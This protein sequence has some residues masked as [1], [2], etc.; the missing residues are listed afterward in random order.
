MASPAG[1]RAPLL[2]KRHGGGAAGGAPAAPP[3]SARASLLSRLE[4]PDARSGTA[5]GSV[6]NLVNSAVGSGMLCFP[7]AYRAAGLGVALGVSATAWVTTTFTLL[8]LVR[9]GN[10]HDARTLQ[11]LV[12][13]ALGRR[14]A[15]VT[16]VVVTLYIFGAC[17]SYLIILS[18]SLEV[19]LALAL[20]HETDVTL[21]RIGLSVVGWGLVYPLCLLRSL[22]SLERVSAGTIAAALFILGVVAARAFGGAHPPAESSN[23]SWV[24]LTDWLDAQTSP[25]NALPI[26]LLAYQSHIQV[27]PILYELGH[28]GANDSDNGAGASTGGD[29]LPLSS[30][31]ADITGVAGHGGLA[32]ELTTLRGLHVARVARW[33]AREARMARFVAVAS[34]MCSALYVAMGVLGYLTFGDAAGAVKSNILDSYSSAD[35]LAKVARAVVG[36]NMIVSYP[37]N[38]FCARSALCDLVLATRGRAGEEPSLALR[39]SIT[40]AFFGLTYAVALVVTN[41]GAVFDIVG[42]TAGVYVILI[43][44]AMLLLSQSCEMQ[45]VFTCRAPVAAALCVGGAMVMLSTVGMQALNIL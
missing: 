23:I 44:P 32:A 7:W 42:A 45:G 29:V 12:S 2:G 36:L 39:C 20:P 30:P 21:R 22:S 8:V 37:V 10:V 26:A 27:V 25:L 38:C 15:L 31:P 40:T 18:D 11:E 5:S 4:P 24:H 41:L 16:S 1:E 19:P 3:S 28:V 17:C 13:R 43:L 35:Q 14:W 34:G 6:F 9:A 33:S